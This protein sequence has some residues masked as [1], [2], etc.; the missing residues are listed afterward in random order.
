MYAN[1]SSNFCN[2]FSTSVKW[3]LV[4]G[5]RTVLGLY[6]QHHLCWM[7]L[8]QRGY[9]LE[10]FNLRLRHESHACSM[11]HGGNFSR[12]ESEVVVLILSEFDV[13]AIGVVVVEVFADDD[14]LGISSI[15]FRR[16]DT[17]VT[18]PDWLLE[19]VTDEDDIGGKNK[20]AISDSESSVFRS[21]DFW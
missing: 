20:S 18:L 17:S 9:S 3:A 16:S 8:E 5:L 10:H 7:H 6:E 11:G 2:L 19:D 14:E 4:K 12:E 1:K 21:T 13:F 15:C